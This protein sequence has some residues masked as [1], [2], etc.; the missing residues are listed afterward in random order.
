MLAKALI[1]AVTSEI[2]I[3]PGPRELPIPDCATA[4]TAHALGRERAGR[5]SET[6]AALGA[7]AADAHAPSV[8]S[9]ANVAAFS[10]NP[11]SPWITIA[12]PRAPHAA[13]RWITRASKG[14]SDVGRR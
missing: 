9:H 12:P 6:A 5:G 4:G 7:P 3:A 13:A 14:G 8:A 1:L 10:A 11:T 2:R